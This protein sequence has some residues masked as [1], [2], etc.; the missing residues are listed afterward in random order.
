VGEMRDYETAAM[1]VQA[2]LTGHLVFSTLH[3]NDAPGAVVR[4]QDMGIP[5]YLIS[6]SLRAVIAQR[7]VRV[8]CPDCAE[9]YRPDPALIEQFGPQ[10][11]RTKKADFRRGAGC[12]KCRNTGF[13]SRTGIFEI[14]P[15]G[16]SLRSLI[17]RK[18]SSG[19][20][21]AEAVRLG[22][23][24]LVEDGWRKACGGITTLDEALQAAH[25]DT[26]I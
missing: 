1:G 2:A 6:S 4:L 8:V 5:P 17:L 11:A 16:E 19:E 10:A 3:T 13:H 21:R 25:G 14:M 23:K 15:V 9:P 7:L 20:I 12:D 18:A 26:A 24:S 22:M